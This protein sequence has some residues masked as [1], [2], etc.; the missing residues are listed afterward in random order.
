MRNF[1]LA[2]VKITSVTIIVSNVN[3]D[4]KRLYEEK[5]REVEELRADNEKLRA[6]NEKMRASTSTAVSFVCTRVLCCCNADFRARRRVS[7]ACIAYGP[8]TKCS[9]TPAKRTKAPKDLPRI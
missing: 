4:Y 3:I 5:C 8:R 9:N 1:N 7:M 6:E 2:L